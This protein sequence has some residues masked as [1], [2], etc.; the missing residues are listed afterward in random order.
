MKD[1]SC[2]LGDYVHMS[3]YILQTSLTSSVAGK[4]LNALVQH[5]VLSDMSGVSRKWLEFSKCNIDV[6]AS[7]F[8]GLLNY[9]YTN[10]T[11]LYTL[12]LNFSKGINSEY[13]EATK[14][15]TNK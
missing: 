11:T 8:L 5:N 4:C 13:I 2:G 14:E 10:F 15:V 6:H 1:A 12:S 3:T 9:I 7:S